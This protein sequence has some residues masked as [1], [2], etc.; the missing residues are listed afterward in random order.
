M[1]PAITTCDFKHIGKCNGVLCAAP[2]F[3]KYKYGKFV[4]V[5]AGHLDMLCDIRGDCDFCK[6]I[7]KYFN[8]RGAP[9]YIEDMYF[10][11]VRICG[12]HLNKIKEALKTVATRVKDTCDI[13]ECQNP[14]IGVHENIRFCKDHCTEEKNGQSPST[15]PDPCSSFDISLMQQILN[16]TDIAVNEDDGDAHGLIDIN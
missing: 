9:K 11:G 6:I 16:E 13:K 2:D 10:P 7:T 15:C 12:K 5:C 1:T 14:A 8:C 3:V 4:R